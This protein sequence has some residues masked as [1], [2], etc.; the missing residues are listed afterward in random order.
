MGVDL[1]LEVRKDHVARHQPM[2]KTLIHVFTPLSLEVQRNT[3]PTMGPALY[4][5]WRLLIKWDFY[6]QRSLP[7]AFGTGGSDSSARALS[8]GDAAS[9]ERPQGGAGSGQGP[10]ALNYAGCDLDDGVGSDFDYYEQSD[11]GAQESSSSEDD[12]DEV[13][14]ELASLSRYRD[15]V[16]HTQSQRVLRSGV[17]SQ[18]ATR[19]ASEQSQSPVGEAA[20]D[21]V[22]SQGVAADDELESLREGVGDFC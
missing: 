18:A 5:V 4:H 10:P 8:T 20:A 7:E 17:A 12:V 16:D 19:G 21:S 22:E 3:V 11:D 2:V 15:D 1:E 9:M 6:N 13:G 14:G